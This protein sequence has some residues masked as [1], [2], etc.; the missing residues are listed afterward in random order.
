MSK[1][2]RP[3]ED[4]TTNPSVMLRLEK[5]I[6]LSQR[7]HFILELLALPERD[8]SLV[9]KHTKILC[10]RTRGFYNPPR[11]NSGGPTRPNYFTTKIRFGLSVLMSL[12]NGS[13]DD[14]LADEGRGFGSGEIVDRLINTYHLYLS[15]SKATPEEADVS[16]EIFVYS[17]RNIHLGQAVMDHCDNCG[18]IHYIFHNSPAQGCP[19]CCQ[20]KLAILPKTPANPP[21]EVWAKRSSATRRQTVQPVSPRDPD[22]AARA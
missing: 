4:W 2:E 16:F 18:S 8:I 17:W 7:T 14:G 20:L 10:E 15:L 1:S 21:S 5:I 6:K 13:A 22:I 3:A 11:G 19:V 9:K 12:M